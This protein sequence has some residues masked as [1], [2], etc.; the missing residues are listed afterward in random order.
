[1]YGVFLI[2]VLVITGGA[3]AFI[4]DRL[5]SKIGK[6]RL[7]L[8]GLRPR[9]TSILVTILTG[10][11]IT[12]LTFGV[13]AAT[14][15]NVRT[16]LFGMEKLNQNMRDTQA[17]LT[18]ASGE[19]AS[20]QA[21]QQQTE[22]DLKETKNELDDLQGQQRQLE[23]RSRALLEGNRLVRALRELSQAHT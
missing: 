13:M 14:S 18:Q 6:K 22:S 15:E 11:C 1:M 8:F 3:I 20:A 21:E 2:V 12:T 17:K 10:V 5:G 9:H 16:A 7:S 23:E 19:L 4:G